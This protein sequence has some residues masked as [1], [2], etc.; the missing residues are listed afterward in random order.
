M[1]RP[2]PT[3]KPNRITTTSCNGK[4][5][6]LEGGRRRCPESI[7]IGEEGRRGGGGGGQQQEWR[8]PPASASRRRFR[9]QPLALP[10]PQAFS[11]SGKCPLP[12]PC[13]GMLWFLAAMSPLMQYCSFSIHLSKAQ[14]KVLHDF[15]CCT[16]SDVDIVYFYLFL[17]LAHQVTR[18]FIVNFF[19]FSAI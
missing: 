9:L 12:R 14:I 7:E 10:A 5:E 17:T 8:A 4:G 1:G 13:S 11:R 18:T 2:K 15:R 3:K 6:K 19:I 16:S